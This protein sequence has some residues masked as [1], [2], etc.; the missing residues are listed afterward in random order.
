MDFIRVLLVHHH[1][2]EW[3]SVV[4]HRAEI[5]VQPHNQIL[6]ARR[7]RNP[8]YSSSVCL[9]G[10]ASMESTSCTFD[11]KYC[12][13]MADTRLCSTPPLPCSAMCV[14][15]RAVPITVCSCHLSPL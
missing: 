8:R 15:R 12:D 7:F 13:R 9:T 14:P 4:Q 10:S 6:F 3:G 11:A 1:L 5:L 2:F